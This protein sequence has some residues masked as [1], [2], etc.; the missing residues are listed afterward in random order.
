MN[1]NDLYHIFQPFAHFVSHLNLANMVW[2]SVQPSVNG[3]GLR[4]WGMV[5]EGGS[6]DEMVLVWVQDECFTW[7]NQHAGKQCQKRN[8]IQLTLPGCKH[9]SGTN[10]IIIHII[11]F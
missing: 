2:S 6:E 3:T 7:P 4:V 11:I 8:S 10:I 5:G 9:T 1:P